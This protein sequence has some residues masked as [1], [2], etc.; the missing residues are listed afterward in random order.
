MKNIKKPDIVLFDLDNTLYEYNSSHNEAL[1]SVKLK[2][3]N[4]L[5][6]EENEF[7]LLYDEAKNNQ[8]T[9]T[10]NSFIS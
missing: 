1:N 5:N 2:V 7:N 3:K 9:N 8:K 10:G 4:L 6:I